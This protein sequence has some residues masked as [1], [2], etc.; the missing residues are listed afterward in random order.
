MRWSPDGRWLAYLRAGQV[1]V[2]RPDGSDRRS[3]TSG[4]MPSGSRAGSTLA[5]SASGRLA[6][7]DRYGLR[8]VD[9]RAGT[10]RML[11]SESVGVIAW[12]PDATSLAYEATRTH[13]LRLVA[14][15]GHP[16]TLRRFAATSVLGSPQWAP[17]PFPGKAPEPVRLARRT[18]SG[19]ELP[20][21]V[22]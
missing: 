15:G 20:M 8:I 6:I 17:R 9:A 1:E 13:A 22:R 2:V 14:I 10:P 12:S 4:V 7:A 5:W 18:A 16:R 19:P 21:G 11:D 3:V